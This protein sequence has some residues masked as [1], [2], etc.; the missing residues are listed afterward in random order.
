MKGVV[1][2]II[3]IVIVMGIAYA[4]VDFPTHPF[5]VVY[6]W[7]DEHDPERDKYI[8]KI[9][10][11]ST[12]VYRYNNTNELLYS[13]KSL[14]KYCNSVST[15]YIVVKDGQVPKFIDFSDPS[16]KLINHSQ[17]IESSALPTFN[18]CVIELCLHKIPNLSDHYVYFND[19]IFVNRK[20]KW[21]D[22][23]SWWNGMPKVN[24][25]KGKNDAVVKKHQTYNFFVS[26]DNTIRLANR[27]L[28]TDVKD[29]KL[30]HTPSVCYKPWEYEIENLLK[31]S[32]LWEDTINSKFRETNNI[33]LNN[34]FRTVFYLSKG[35]QRANWGDNY[36]ALHD[37][38]NIDVGNELFFC[39]NNISQKCQNAF[40]EYMEAKTA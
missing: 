19:D 5:D 28:N 39:V 26:Y 37:N 35:A 24:T 36:I 14:R 38:C 34:G 32:G 11:E 30:P 1:V 2:L 7:V 20:L 22:L 12:S 4:L 3:I 33:I 15:I 27:L 21:R 25:I 40:K 10:D 23:F 17:I 29:I 31:R 18:S 9:V 8:G 16:I 13:I 6:T